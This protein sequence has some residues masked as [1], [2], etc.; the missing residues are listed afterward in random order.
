MCVC[1]CV[2]TEKMDPFWER[3]RRRQCLRN[4]AGPI[5]Y[6]ERPTV[7]RLGDTKNIREDQDSLKS[8]LCVL[9]V[10]GGIL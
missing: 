9:D 4:R 10:Q 6:G 8:V 1:V 2:L 7:S 5:V 3:E